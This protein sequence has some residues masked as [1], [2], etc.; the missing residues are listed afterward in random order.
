MASFVLSGGNQQFVSSGS[1]TI[2]LTTGEL[3]TVQ[4]GT[5]AGSFDAGTATLIT[6]L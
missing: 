3:T 1:G 5:S 6:E 2:T 4:L